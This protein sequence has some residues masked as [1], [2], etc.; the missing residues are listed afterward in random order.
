MAT[1]AGPSKQHAKY[2]D[3]VEAQ[4]EKA[5]KRIRTLD[6]MTA[7]L[8]FAAGTL[9]YA[10]I[11]ALLDNALTLPP[12][13][14]YIGFFLYLAGALAYLG[15]TIVRP[16]TARIN[17]YFAARQVE[18]TLPG[19]KNSVVNWLD[20][21]ADAKLPTAIHGAVSQKAARDLAKAD[22]ER[23]V[24]GRRAGWMGG[25]VAGLVVVLLVLLVSLGGRRLFSHLGRAFLPFSGQ[26]VATQTEI[27]LLE[28]QDGNASIAAGQSFTV[29]ATVNGRV[30]ETLKLITRQTK[31]DPEQEYTLDPD[32]AAPGEW[33]AT[34]Q[35]AEVKNGFF[36]RVVGGDASTPEYYVNVHAGPAILA[37][38][39]TAT[40][41]HRPY[42]GQQVE[43]VVRKDRNL[44]DY[45]G[46]SVTLDVPTNRKLKSGEALLLSADQKQQR[47]VRARIVAGKETALSVQ[48]VLEWSGTYFI[49]FESLAGERY[50]DAPPFS[51]VALEDKPPKVDLS[52]PGKDETL[53]A[54]AL[55]KLKGTASD[56]I[57]VK[58][59]TLRLKTAEG[60]ALKPKPYRSPEALKLADGGYSNLVEYQDFLDLAKVKDEAG[61]P[62][63]LT[64]G[65]VLEYW[66]EARDACDYPAPKAGNVAESKHFKVTIGEPQR[67][68]KKKEQQRQQANKEQ[69]QHEKKQEQDK[70]KQEQKRQQQNQK[71][72]KDNQ[73][74]RDEAAGKE[75]KE[76]K[77]DGKGKPKEG[78][79]AG[80]DNRTPEE[81][82]KDEERQKQK[83]KL[84]EAARK[85]EEQQRQEQQKAEEQRRQNEQGEGKGDG[86]KDKRA[87]AKGNPDGQDQPDKKNQ[88][89]KAGQQEPN[90]KGKDNAGGKPGEGQDSKAK[91]QPEKDSAHDQSTG[92]GKGKP[93]DGKKDQ[94]STK[95][96]AG[97]KD[98]E[99][100]A[101]GKDDPKQQQQ[102]QQRDGR[103]QGKSG[104]DQSKDGKSANKGKPEGQ[105]QP[106]GAKGK[107]GGKPDSSGQPKADKKDAGGMEGDRQASAK[108]G[109]EQ[110]ADSTQQANDGSRQGDRQ[111]PERGAA[112]G[113]GKRDEQQVAQDKSA[114]GQ[115]EKSKGKEKGKEQTADSQRS[116]AKGEPR[117]QAKGQCKECKGGQSAGAGKPSSKGNTQ[118]R[119][120]TKPTGADGASGTSAAKDDRI[121]GDPQGRSAMKK[122][123]DE[124]NREDVKNLG[125]DLKSDDP[126]VRQD[127]ERKLEEA[128]REGKDERVRQEAEEK[129][130]ESRG[131]KP[132]ATVKKAPGEGQQAGQP[133]DGNQ[134]EKTAQAKG[135]GQAKGQG[136]GKK[137]EKS[138][139]TA[140]RGRGKVTG[141]RGQQQA[142]APQ[143]VPED[144]GDGRFKKHAGNL[145]LERFSEKVR[146]KILKDAG[147]TEE[148]YKQLQADL[149]RRPL[150]PPTPE[151]VKKPVV[152]EGTALPTGPATQVRTGTDKPGVGSNDEGLPP[153]EY[154]ELYKKLTE[155]LT[156]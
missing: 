12:A 19:A 53:A 133:K 47:T 154:R 95:D 34:V 64:P 24:S 124:L 52:E 83:E 80:K 49:R 126:K 89:E 56:D 78:G 33:V 79:N 148:Q 92:K 153:L 105:S 39:F 96:N 114:Q 144:P 7:L 11:M 101:Q 136:Q 57:G 109:K 99:Q 63:A 67:D 128:R 35:A 23:A 88:G 134:G 155:E 103:A 21:H 82:K 117:Q 29:R 86:A 130:G 122:P 74:A 45:R 15:L 54:D 5:R 118:A 42:F 113:K 44:Q 146:K 58:E 132:T 127:A 31:T 125:E 108:D 76:G 119:S 61:K 150:P 51:V 2:D 26:G 72:E 48:F 81:K 4:L 110:G 60:V 151:P 37:E 50:V 68:E 147:L 38:R 25:I 123:A 129:L 115:G 40:Y 59:L 75:G 32:K 139:G 156:K 141:A 20:L 93:E 106:S 55:L 145:N 152:K 104:A 91:P 46:T 3:F 1:V 8:G 18:Q 142:A 90:G 6:V 71:Q 131:G 36:Y 27:V 116:T 107:D 17:P 112:K 66:L 85:A 94:A 28:P 10:V 30:P 62:F 137:D 135:S 138:E 121:K 70:Q 140:D 43:R 65:M 16:L 9:A 111:Q 77:E 14:L 100:P 84:E 102:P 13:A 98:G 97:M 87:E 41:R 69:Q 73:Q 22:L 143:D 120:E 149:K